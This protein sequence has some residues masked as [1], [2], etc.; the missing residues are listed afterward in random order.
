LRDTGNSFRR[1]DGAVG[2]PGDVHR[3]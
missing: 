2:C 1:P 3:P